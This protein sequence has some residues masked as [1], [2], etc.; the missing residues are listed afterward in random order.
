MAKPSI[1]QKIYESLGPQLRILYFKLIRNKVK[2]NGKNA[3]SLKKTD[4][5]FIKPEKIYFYSFIFFPFFGF[6]VTFP[7]SGP[8][9]FLADLFVW[10]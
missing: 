5:D 10:S 6:F 7:V 9:R 8:F 4:D 2:Q 3:Q 1:L